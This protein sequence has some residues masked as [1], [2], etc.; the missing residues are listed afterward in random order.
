MI[1][2]HP[3]E[4]VSF[5]FLVHKADII[6]QLWPLMI[7]LAIFSGGIAYLELVHLKL[8]ETTYIKN[9]G[10]MYIPIIYLLTRFAPT[11]KDT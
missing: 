6:R 8:T 1:N 4:W 10:M 5:I 3:K 9:V 7:S 2:Y 11:L